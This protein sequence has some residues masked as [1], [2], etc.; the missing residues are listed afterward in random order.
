MKKRLF[1]LLLCVAMLLGLAV[2]TFAD[3]GTA[4][5]TTFQ[6][7]KDA[8]NDNGVSAIVIN[9]DITIP[10]TVSISKNLTLKKTVTA[11]ASVE[12]CQG[13]TVTLSG[14]ENGGFGKLEMRP[15]SLS[16]DSISGPMLYNTGKIEGQ[17]ALWI[18]SGCSYQNEGVGTIDTSETEF[19]VARFQNYLYGPL[20]ITAGYPETIIGVT[21]QNKAIVTNTAE[22]LAA[23]ADAAAAQGADLGAWITLSDAYYNVEALTLTS[24]VIVPSWLMADIPVEIPTGKTLTLNGDYNSFNNGLS[25]AGTLCVNGRL[26]NYREIYIEDGGVLEIPDSDDEITYDPNKKDDK[27]NDVGWE[28][29]SDHI[30]FNRN[31][32]QIENGGELN[33]GG[34]LQNEGS[35]IVAGTM[36]INATAQDNT[37]DGVVNGAARNFG[38]L[39]INGG[40]LNI[41]TAANKFGGVLVNFG[42]L[43]VCRNSET[44]TDGEFTVDGQV[45]NFGRL[46]QDAGEINVNG[47]LNNGI[48]EYSGDSYI[49]L[50]GGA[51]NVSGYVR[52]CNEININ[53]GSSLTVLPTAGQNYTTEEN[54]PPA[55][56]QSSV[57]CNNF[58]ININSGGTLT[59]EAGDGQTTNNGLLR[60]NGAVNINNDGTLDLKGTMDNDAKVWN[61][62]S[63]KVYDSTDIYNHG[64]LYVKDSA[65]FGGGDYG[66][67]NEI[68]WGNIADKTSVLHDDEAYRIWLVYGPDYRKLEE[69]FYAVKGSEQYGN[70]VMF[71]QDYFGGWVDAQGISVNAENKTQLS[72]NNQVVRIGTETERYGTFR[73]YFENWG[74]AQIVLKDRD[75][76]TVR[77]Y[78]AGTSLDYGGFYTYYNFEQISDNNSWNT[79]TAQNSSISNHSYNY[80]NLDVSGSG[81]GEMIWFAKEHGFSER[82][83]QDVDI[84]INGENAQI[85]SPDNAT[86]W[87]DITYRGKVIL[88]CKAVQRGWNNGTQ[89]GAHDILIQFPETAT[90][91]FSLNIRVAD[92]ENYLECRR[93]VVI[94]EDAAT[95]KGKTATVTVRAENCNNLKGYQLYLKYDASKLEYVSSQGASGQDPIINDT[96]SG[97]LSAVIAAAAEDTIPNG[98]LFTLTFKVKDTDA[99]GASEDI[100]IEFD[101]GKDSMMAT[102]AYGVRT[103]NLNAALQNGKIST[104]IPGDVV[105]DGKVNILDAVQLVRAVAKLVDLSAAEYQA[106][107]VGTGDTPNVD[108]VRAILKYLADGTKLVHKPTGAIYG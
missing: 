53:G 17:G 85:G 67:F 93:P 5:V 10:E 25:I 71:G 16:N 96:G 13:V 4:T 11:T 2:P 41:K 102:L 56:P 54:A 107:L 59:V 100:A 55:N 52:Y 80:R 19:C 18:Y 79:E 6:E 105:R 81:D 90:E 35:L 74:D 86:G 60:N 26:E 84:R 24:D 104:V 87:M 92:A 108:G 38:F 8:L 20:N 76:K 64:H 106:A 43:N 42:E 27:G 65:T 48:Q 40:K 34:A 39:N 98:E 83:L 61:F 50:N 32:L 47:T 12:I 70:I 15:D 23:A 95:V 21:P 30:L 68:N 88:K 94:I 46:N 91:D 75:N 63:F 57:L 44:Q 89:D 22:G 99:V 77:T 31:T 97:T 82:D 66:D 62:G 49:D 73:I 101:P 103:A 9:A 1:S 28:E 78:D 14:W 72:D 51:M 58:L 3:G 7:L 69:Q 45:Y 29:V 36:N 33:V 37:K